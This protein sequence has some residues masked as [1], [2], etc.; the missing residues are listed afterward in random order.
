MQSRA[1]AKADFLTSIA[2]F[3]LGVY[4][5]VEGW[6]LPGAGGFIE[7]GGEPGRVPIMLGAI[8]AIFAVILM[9][10]SVARQGHRLTE[11]TE[12]TE[13]SAETRTGVRRSAIT[14]IG[15][16]LYAVGVLGSKWFGWH[17]PYPLATGLF[18]FL[19]ITG[20]EWDSAPEQG[21][22][23]WAWLETKAPSFAGR[24]R[25][26]FGFVGPERAPYV[27]LI[28]TALVQAVLV[29]WAV[30]YLFERQFFVQLP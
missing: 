11:K 13:T 23:R 22:K 24:I 4:M 5:I 17:V 10:R 20:F 7:Q 26:A 21:A 19:F 1:M 9:T 14:A 15:C 8:L 18:L 28:L 3:I 29:S 12:A 30:S 16:S 25:S 2:F 6:R 27:W